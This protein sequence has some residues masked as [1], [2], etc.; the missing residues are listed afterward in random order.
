VERCPR[1]ARELGAPFG[2]RVNANRADGLP[3]WE[4]IQRSAIWF[5]WKGL[6][7]ISVRVRE[8]KTEIPVNSEWNVVSDA[9]RRDAGN[10][11]LA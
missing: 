8:V 10:K 6:G 3:S 9:Q 2:L 7:C 1:N 4:M 5:T 11:G